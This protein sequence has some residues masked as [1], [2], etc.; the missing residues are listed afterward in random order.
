[1]TDDN[2]QTTADGQLS[3][4]VQPYYR[5]AGEADSVTEAAEILEL[6]FA[7]AERREEREGRHE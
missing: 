4:T 2:S 7:H 3:D 1:M 6:G 5:A